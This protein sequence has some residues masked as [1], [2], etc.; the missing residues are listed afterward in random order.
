MWASSITTLAPPVPGLVEPRKK[1][2]QINHVSKFAS[3][4]GHQTSTL[5]LLGTGSS[6]AQLP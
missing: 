1:P 2:F 4:I 6:R 3:R 5:A